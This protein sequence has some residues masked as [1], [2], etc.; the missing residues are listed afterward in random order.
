M[1]IKQCAFYFPCVFFILMFVLCIISLSFMD[2]VVLKDML[3]NLK[4]CSSLGN[5][6]VV[7]VT[8]VTTVLV[9]M[10]VLVM[11]LVLAVMVVV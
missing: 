2:V 8:V 11:I 7:V 10:A 3:E 6:V 5:F 9:V 1:S 4:H